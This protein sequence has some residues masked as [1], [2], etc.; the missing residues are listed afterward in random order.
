MTV[1]DIPR[2]GSHGAAAPH[3]PAWRDAF[4]RV[5][6]RLLAPQL[7]AALHPT[8]LRVRGL[9]LFMLVGH[10]LFW[11]IWAVHLPQPYESLPLRLAGAGLG[12]LLITSLVSRDPSTRLSRHVFNAVTWL[13]LPLFFGWMYL[14]NGGNAVWLASTAA[15]ILAYYYIA[16]WRLAT[17]GLAAAAALASLLFDLWG[18]ALAPMTQDLLVANTVVLLFC[19]AMG[20]LLGLSSTNLRHE[21][22]AHTVSTVGIVAHELRTPLATMS[23]IGD[24]I[25]GSAG[26]SHSTE[27][28]QRLEQLAAR[29]HVLVRNMNHHIDM[30]VTNARPVRMPT[31]TSPIRAS[32]LVREAV[33]SYPFR[34]TRERDCVRVRI[35]DDFVFRGSPTLFRQVID[36]L[37]KNAMTSLAA[38]TNSTAAGDLVVHVLSSGGLG[39][40]VVTDRGVGIAAAHLPRVFD[41][42]FSTHRGTGHGLGLAFCRQVV[43]HARGDIRAHSQPGGGAAFTIELPI[44]H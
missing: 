25:R 5:R 35:Q 8:P 28:A 31:Q 30:Q 6:E 34:S 41:A 15:M 9:G 44:L 42:F 36:N 40:I 7:A 19:M 20:L 37:I 3:L 1:Q 13:G 23:L 18:P 10:P 43:S 33:S 17:L 39:Q 4:R 38:A 16:D 14:C 12:L 22:L 32:N 26:D 2:P 24:A 27:A 11:V 21:Q 29:L